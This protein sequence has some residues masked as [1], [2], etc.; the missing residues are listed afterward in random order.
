MATLT[1]DGTG[2]DDAIVVTVTGPDSGNYTINGGAPV[3][4]SGV[5]Q[6]NV[7]GLAGNDTLTMVNS[8][9]FLADALSGGL[10]DDTY[11]LNN[12][13]DQVVENANE[14]IDTVYA[15]VTYTLPT[16]VEN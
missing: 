2:G 5:T 4:F 10:G 13:G 11:V 8:A 14:G 1:I 6:V 12:T 15:F 7:N 9:G 3:A 16:N